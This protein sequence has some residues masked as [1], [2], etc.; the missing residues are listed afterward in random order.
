M[1]VTVPPADGAMGLAENFATGEAFGGGVPPVS[2]IRSASK[3]SPATALPWEMRRSSV[4]PVAQPVR[5]LR[6]A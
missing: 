6:S 1:K 4:S 5:S 3:A 2:V